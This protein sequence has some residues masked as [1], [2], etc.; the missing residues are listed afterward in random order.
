MELRIGSLHGAVGR[1]QTYRDLTKHFFGYRPKNLVLY[2]LRMVARK[3]QA[4]RIL[5]ISNSGFFANN[6]LRVDRKL[7]TSLIDGIDQVIAKALDENV[8]PS[9]RPA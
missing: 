3:L 5:A 6:H 4:V 8:I 9:G 7:Q 1:L 2:A